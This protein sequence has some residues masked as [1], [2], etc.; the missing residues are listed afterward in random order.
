MEVK[1]VGKNEP[2]ITNDKGGM[3]A[4]VLYGFHLCDPKA[5]LALA[6][7]MQYGATKYA[8]DNWRK[9]SCEEHINHAIIHFFAYLAGDRSDQHLEHAFTRGMMAVATQEAEE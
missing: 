2:I 5:M 8:R 6:E 9:I 7:V 3:Q 4:R 1:G